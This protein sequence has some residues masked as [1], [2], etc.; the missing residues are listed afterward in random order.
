MLSQKQEKFFSALL[1]RD[2]TTKETEDL[3]RFQRL[4]GIRDDDALW[5]LY[6]G[7]HYHT[8]LYRDIPTQIEHASEKVR[9]DLV[10]SAKA[11]VAAIEAESKREVTKTFKE[12]VDKTAR[13]L[14]ETVNETSRQLS[15][16]ISATELAR[17]RRELVQ[18]VIGGGLVLGMVLTMLFF[19]G[20]RH[21][22]EEGYAKGK[23][24]G[25]AEARAKE[26]PS[27]KQLGSAEGYEK[28]KSEKAAASW[29]A[30][31]EGRA[32][33]DLARR[34]L[35]SHA[36]TLGAGLPVLAACSGKGWSAENGV[37]FPRATP[38]GRVQ[39]WRI[40]GAAET[41]GAK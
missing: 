36:I 3:V 39:G 35:L 41:E 11:S 5:A 20:K 27:W 22:H 9:S 13:T 31:T 6:L 33:H 30:T 29:A 23:A 32:A 12:L 19:M 7:L 34:G 2:V 37:C 18:W 40:T 21:G 16:T 8:L 1:G 15:A 26:S 17:A 25:Y 28:A 10:S 14:K 4:L 24:D 38:D